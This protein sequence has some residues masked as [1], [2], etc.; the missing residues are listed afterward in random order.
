MNKLTD[1]IA[2]YN[3][4]HGRTAT[5]LTYLLPVAQQWRDSL[6]SHTEFQWNENIGL[7]LAADKDLR[8]TFIYITLNQHLTDD[9]IIRLVLS[10]NEPKSRALAVNIMQDAYGNPDSDYD[11]NRLIA[12]ITN[13]ATALESKNTFVADTA[14]TVIAF[15]DL[16]LGE[17]EEAETLAT[18]AAKHDKGN[19][20]AAIVLTMIHDKK[21]PAKALRMD[22]IL[23]NA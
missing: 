4:R 3:T 14:A 22:N 8:D 13:L 16:Y 20:L 2:D 1:E 12:A 9:D 10:P 15:L 5:R 23:A 18:I 17:T 7:M 11:P 19:T 6:D 21:L